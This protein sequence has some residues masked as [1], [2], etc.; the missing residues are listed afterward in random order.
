[1]EIPLHITIN[2]QRKILI[3]CTP[4]L[5]RE[6]AVGF[7]FT[8]GL[9]ENVTDIRECKIRS[10]LSDEGEEIAEASITLSASLPAP[11]D[12][13]KRISYS[14]CG[15][16]GAENYYGLKRGLMR[17][18]SKQRFSMEVL[19]GLPEK[20]EKAQPLYQRTGGSHAAMM[21]DASG[22]PLFRCEDMGRHNALDKLIGFCL[23]QDISP[24][25]KILV[26]SG[27]ASLEMVLKTAKAGF[28]LFLALS[29]PTSRAVEAAKYYNITV[30]DMAKGS[31]RIYSHVR[32]IEGF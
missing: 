18:R 15:I 16:C 11:S 6:L 27:R 14:S 17:V 7:S 32:R 20:L 30:V 23:L 21:F 22:T 3:M 5:T 2:Q 19:K 1:V 28:P 9:I 26:S 25:D 10:V 8:E 12:T 24:G 29:R 4:G 13:A 31:N